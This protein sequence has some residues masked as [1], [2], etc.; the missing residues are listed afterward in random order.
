MSDVRQSH[1]TIE[2]ELRKA[3]IAKGD[4][5]RLSQIAGAIYKTGK[6]FSDREASRLRA[7]ATE[8]YTGSEAAEVIE[9]WLLHGKWVE[10][11][12]Q[13]RDE[14]VPVDP[15][16]KIDDSHIRF[17]TDKNPYGWVPKREEKLLYDDHNRPGEWNAYRQ[18]FNLSS[19]QKA[20][21]NAPDFKIRGCT[22]WEVLGNGRQPTPHFDASV[23]EMAKLTAS[24]ANSEPERKAYG[25]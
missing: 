17:V 20:E 10:I 12:E 9:Q 15:N 6:F 2:N 7:K 11:N 13:M 8:Q 19:A 21:A 25:E 3:G 18:A 24:E 22:R 5:M 4:S 16:A 1:K 14:G 23:V